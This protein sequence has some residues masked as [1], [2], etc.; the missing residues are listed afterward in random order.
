MGSWDGMFYL[1]LWGI[2][3]AKQVALGFV[4]SHPLSAFIFIF[5]LQKKKKEKKREKREKKKEK[6]KVP[7]KRSRIKTSWKWK[8]F[9]SRME[10]WKKDIVVQDDVKRRIFQKQWNKQ[11]KWV[12]N[13]PKMIETISNIRNTLSI[14]T[15]H[16]I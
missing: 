16:K 8:F 4:G 9:T 13:D 3:Q 12:Y 11:R 1:K 5:A 2:K 7:N 14:N 6:E 15:S 10:K